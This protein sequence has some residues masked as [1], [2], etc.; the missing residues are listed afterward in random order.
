MI[1]TSQKGRGTKIHL[2]IDGEYKITTDIEFWSINSVADGTD[3]SEEEWEELVS[4]VN[5]RKAFNK[6]ADYL[7]RRSHSEKELLDKVIK[8]GVDRESAVKAIERFKE[9]GYINDRDFAFEYTEY[10]LNSKRYSL[11]RVKQELFYKGIS[12]DIISE[13]IDGIE[14]DQAQTVINIINKSYVRKLNE[15]GGREKVITALMRRGFSYSDIKEACNR[16]ENDE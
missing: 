7:S 6:C 2:L 8:G 14:T 12:K 3:L 13:A 10:L 16:L 9:L 15:E 4:A 11:N 5:Y 1:I